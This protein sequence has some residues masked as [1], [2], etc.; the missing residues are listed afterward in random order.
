MHLKSANPHVVMMIN[1]WRTC[2]ARNTVV[3]RVCP[4][5]EISPQ[6]RLLFLKILSYTQRA[7]EVKK[8]VGFSLKRLRCGDPA[9]PPLNGHMVGHFLQKAR[10]RIIV[11]EG[12]EY[13]RRGFCTSVHS[14]SIVVTKHY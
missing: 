12:H 6:E 1:P 9:L 3:V 14:L 2:A 8:I 5:F 13:P 4:A 11:I 10:M 7:T